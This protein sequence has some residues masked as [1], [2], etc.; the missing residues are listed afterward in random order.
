MRRVTRIQR[1]E[2]V[3]YKGSVRTACLLPSAFLASFLNPLTHSYSLACSLLFNKLS[4]FLTICP[5][6][7]PSPG[8]R[9]CLN[10]VWTSFPFPFVISFSS[11]NIEPAL[12][13]LSFSMPKWIFLYPSH[14]PKKMLEFACFIVFLW[15][16]KNCPWPSLWF[17]F[18]II[19]LVGLSTCKGTLVSPVLTRPYHTH[20]E[21]LFTDCHT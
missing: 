15:D 5:Q 8:I 17:N 14:A 20:F 2:R 13:F 11:T 3:L 6:C 10:S 21:V 12:R 19:L 16:L 4:L 7:S 18:K 1:E 9:C